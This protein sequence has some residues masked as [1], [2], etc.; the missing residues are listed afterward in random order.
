MRRFRFY[1]RTPCV[2]LCLLA[3]RVDARSAQ[4]AW[5]VLGAN[6]AAH[7]ASIK[8]VRHVRAPH[9]PDLALFFRTDLIPVREHLRRSASICGTA[10]EDPYQKQCDRRGAQSVCHTLRPPRVIVAPGL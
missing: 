3:D 10:A 2:R 8:A 5:I 4:T 7:N 6:D 9:A 1:W